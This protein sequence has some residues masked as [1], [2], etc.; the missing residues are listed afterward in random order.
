AQ[1]FEQPDDG[2]L[3]V[4]REVRIRLA[5]F[6]LEAEV[7]TR[8]LVRKRALVDVYLEEFRK[9]VAASGNLVGQQGV[10]HGFRQCRLRGSTNRGRKLTVYQALDLLLRYTGYRPQERQHCAV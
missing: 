3:T 5:F 4:R 10:R 1:R 7:R 6:R 8:Q 2:H 9:C